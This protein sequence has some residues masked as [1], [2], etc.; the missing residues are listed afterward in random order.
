MDRRWK[1]KR[2]EAS[3]RGQERE[4]DK[5]LSEGAIQSQKP[6]KTRTLSVPASNCTSW[7]DKGPGGAGAFAI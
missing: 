2:S 1:V 4:R 3:Q 6:S 5:T 7:R